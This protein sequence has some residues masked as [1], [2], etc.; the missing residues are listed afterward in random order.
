MTDVSEWRSFLHDWDREFKSLLAKAGR[1]AIERHYVWCL[2]FMSGSNLF[3]AGADA[4]QVEQASLRL[5]LHF[6]ADY[7]AFLRAS[8]GLFVPGVVAEGVRLLPVAE[9]GLYRV[10]HQEQY[11]IWVDTGAPWPE[12]VPDDEY[13]VYGDHQHSDVIRRDLLDRVIAI[14]DQL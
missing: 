1:E 4:A 3:C 9:I 8:N 12:C 5:G 10:L 7:V 14:S 13:F 6:P 11:Q 2:Q